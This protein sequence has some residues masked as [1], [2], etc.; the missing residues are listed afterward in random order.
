MYELGRKIVQ[1]IEA[2]IFVERSTVDIYRNC[3]QI[4]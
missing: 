1:E 2:N 3:V 4:L